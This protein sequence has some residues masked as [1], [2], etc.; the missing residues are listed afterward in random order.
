MAQVNKSIIADIFNHLLYTREYAKL[1]S[2]YTKNILSQLNSE[3][4]NVRSKALKAMSLIIEEDPCILKDNEIL[5]SIKQR[6]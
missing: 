4:T 2:C 3:F 6:F 5:T 1:Q